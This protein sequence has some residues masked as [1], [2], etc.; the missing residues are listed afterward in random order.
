MGLRRALVEPLLDLEAHANAVGFLEVAPENWMRLGGRL[1]RPFRALTE[2]FPFVTHGLS[3]AVGS[4]APLHLVSVREVKHVLDAHGI[5]D[6]IEH[7]AF[8]L[9]EG[10]LDD[11]LPIPFTEAAVHYVTARLRQ[12]QDTLERDF[13]LPPMTDLLAEVSAIRP[14]QAAHA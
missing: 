8:C 10:H 9:D 13:N 7:L 11:L 14:R 12:V 1:G 4:P 5:A 6:Y 2:R 3:L